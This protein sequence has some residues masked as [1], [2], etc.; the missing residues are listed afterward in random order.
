MQSLTKTYG[1]QTQT[2]S[3]YTNLNKMTE[4]NMNKLLVKTTSTVII[5]VLNINYRVSTAYYTKR[6]NKEEYDF[7]IENS[8][9]DRKDSPIS[10]QSTFAN[11]DLAFTD[12]A[13]SSS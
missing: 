10:A 4:E 12:T 8:L 2:K 9:W 5:R 7:Y 6:G 1:K 13:D 3:Y 11:G